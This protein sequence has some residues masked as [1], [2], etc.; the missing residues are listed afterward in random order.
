MRNSVKLFDKNSASMKVTE[1]SFFAIASI[2]VL[3]VSFLG[4]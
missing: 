3:Q 1:F 2:L 4:V